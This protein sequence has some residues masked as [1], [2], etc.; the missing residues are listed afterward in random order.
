MKRKNS[1]SIYAVSFVGDVQ[2]EG[3]AS[4]DGEMVAS[5]LEEA[6]LKTKAFLSAF[7]NVEIVREFKEQ[8]TMRNCTVL[9][10]SKTEG[11]FLIYIYEKHV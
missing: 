8:N 3:S 9:T 7:L 10:P 4:M 11:D 6:V 5:S 2:Y 1:D